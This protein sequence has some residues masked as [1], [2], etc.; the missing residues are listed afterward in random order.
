MGKGILGNLLAAVYMDGPEEPWTRNVKKERGSGE[1]GGKSKG[2][3]IGV[4]RTLDREVGGGRNRTMPRLPDAVLDAVPIRAD[5]RV[6]GRWK[7]RS[8]PR[9]WQNVRAQCL[10]IEDH[11]IQLGGESPQLVCDVID[12]ADLGGEVLD[13]SVDFELVSIFTDSLPKNTLS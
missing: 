7:R 5:G 6:A 4:R 13:G 12:G 1:R 10:T 3:G 11:S 9:G 8:R 2:R